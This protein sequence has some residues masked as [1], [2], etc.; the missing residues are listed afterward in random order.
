MSIVMEINPYEFF[1]DTDG[2]AL[3]AGYIYIGQ[4]NLDPRQYPVT[5]YYDAALTIPAAMPL[6]TSNGYIV[7]NGSPTFLY[8]D[9]NYSIR[10]ENKNHRQIFYVP[11]FLLIGSG[12][13]ATVADL[14]NLIRRIGDVSVLQASAGRSNGEVVYLEGYTPGWQATTRGALGFGHFRWDATSVKTANG[15][16]VFAVTDL[17]TGRWL[18]IFGESVSVEDFGAAGDYNGV[19]N[20]NDTDAFQRAINN[21]AE[22]SI[23]RLGKSANY[24]VDPIAGFTGVSNI[25]FIGVK[26]FTTITCGSATSLF[27]VG[28]RSTFRDI[29]LGF[30]GVVTGQGPTVRVAFN[31]IDAS[32]GLVAQFCEFSGIS[33]NSLGCGSMFYTSATGGCF[34]CSFSDIV[35]KNFS[36]AAFNF[37]NPT[38]TQNVYSN[39]Y[40]ISDKQPPRMMQFL[41]EEVGSTF[42]GINFEQSV[43]TAPVLVATNLNAVF[44]NIHLEGLRILGNNPFMLFDNCNIDIDNLE[45]F[46]CTFGSYVSGGATQT[47]GLI[48]FNRNTISVPPYTSRKPYITVKNFTAKGINYRFEAGYVDGLLP[49]ELTFYF[50]FGDSVNPAGVKPIVTIENY[51][52][53]TWISDFDFYSDFLTYDSQNLIP[54][55][56]INFQTTLTLQSGWRT[57]ANS[58][59]VI[60]RYKYDPAMQVTRVIAEFNLAYQD[61]ANTQIL[62]VPSNL[63]PAD[64]KFFRVMRDGGGAGLDI[65][66]GYGTANIF[67]ADAAVGT[68]G[69]LASASNRLPVTI[70]YTV[71]P[72]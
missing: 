6:R 33:V 72:T 11:D 13:A 65:R 63:T 29:Q 47:S 24:Y 59:D 2:D 54:V 43:V 31:L 68:G 50:M 16:T 12:S 52:Y 18:R 7:R 35:A 32:V 21:K 27:N 55:K 9:G 40:M 46:Y 15:G 22:C 51:N 10:V 36:Y 20:T 14:V 60:F 48:K 62:V 67:N 44:T 71:A 57:P 19:V 5:V 70:E 28:E 4:A 30:L 25:T 39:I 37:N 23:I 45:F 53:R 41:G 8:I 26:S 69:A 1:T 38:R 17:P 64:R 34:S 58:T 66:I 42:S 3:D 61:K 56:P 49:P